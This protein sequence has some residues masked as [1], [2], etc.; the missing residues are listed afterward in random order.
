MVFDFDLINRC[1]KLAGLALLGSPAASRPSTRYV[2][3]F[4]LSGTAEVLLARRKALKPFGPWQASRS[5]GPDI[6]QR[7]SSKRSKQQRALRI[8]DNTAGVEE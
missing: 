3:F 1:S 8:E 4:W 6:Y 7:S 2:S 5:V